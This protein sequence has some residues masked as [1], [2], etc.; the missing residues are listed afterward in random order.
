[1]KHA[2]LVTALAA[3]VSTAAGGARAA[4]P[5]TETPMPV[6][7]NMAADGVVNFVYQQFVRQGTNLTVAVAALE[8][9]VDQY[10]HTGV[11]HL[12]WNVNYQR[13]GYASAVWPSY[14]DVPDPETQVT[15][16]PRTYYLLHKLGIDDVFERLIPRT[17]EKGLSPWVSLRMNDHHY[18][19][20]FSR[21]SPLLFNHPEL[22]LNNG[23]GLFNYM[24]PE[25]RDHYLRLAAEVLQ[26]YDIDGLELDWI[27]TPSNFHEAELEQG[28][29]TLTAFIKD[30]RH[31]TRQAAQR[32]GH[33]VSLAVR[34]PATPEFAW[35]K[36]FDAEG[37]AKSGLVDMLI[38]CDWWSGFN[39][40]IPVELW[41]ER[42]GEQGRACLIV[43]GTAG[44]YSCIAKGP[45]MNHSLAAMR[46]FA[47]S[48]YGRG[49]DGLYL[50]NHFHAVTST[51]RTRTPEGASVAE[52]TLADLLR[53]AGDRAAA[54]R[55]PRVHALTLHDCLPTKTAYRT[56]LPAAVTNG[57]PVTLRLHT[58]PRP[59]AGRCELRVGLSDA[60]GLASARLEAC[61][62]GMPCP[63][64]AD[65]PP[66]AKP[67]ANADTPRQ[68]VCE[69]A[70]RV[71]RFNVPLAA[72]AAGDNTVTLALA[73]GVPQTAVWLEMSI[74]PCDTP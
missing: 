51:V 54:V 68:H 7:V 49:A 73:E 41:R 4:T 12:F 24:K 70:P 30:V 66:P 13:T 18:L 16:W 22:R 56:P 34:V 61:V 57:A 62:N 32:R 25:V 52:G 71:V 3:A 48:M 64:L 46:G 10:Q 67:P 9:E 20:D 65:F 27:R 69:V 50:F 37:W 11:T 63:A 28:R 43:P 2:L 72:L 23:K 58:G 31:L 53:A 14:W 33:P 40:A 38:P 1:M 35:G 44:T 74:E 8:K 26:R 39:G 19:G 17:R 5:Q 29:A 21:V 15:E 59:A 60:E 45:Q 36:G 42:L 47:A 55:L 6:I